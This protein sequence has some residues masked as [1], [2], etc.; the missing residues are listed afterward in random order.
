MRK[1]PLVS[2]IFLLLLAACGDKENPRVA[3][4]SGEI[5]GLGDDTLYVIGMDR[6]FDRVD[7]LVVHEDRFSD[8]I[9][10]DTLVGVSLLFADGTTYPLY[11]DRRE[12]IRIS[13]SADRLQ[14]LQVTGSPLN[15][16][17]TAFSQSLA[18]LSAPTD[19]AVQRRA[20]DFIRQ[21]PASLVSLWLLEKYF[22]QVPEPDLDR[23]ES[24][25][26]PLVGEIKDRPLASE[27]M[28][29]LEDHKKLSVGRSL[30]FIQTTD[31]DGERVV[32]TQ[33]NDQYLLVHVWA[34]WD[35]ASRAANDS[36]R[37]LHRRQKRNKDFAMLGIS[38][39][40]DRTMW[41]DAISRDTLDWTQ[42]CDL[43]GW[44]SDVVKKCYVYT[45]PFNVLVN[46]KGRIMGINLTPAQVEEKIKKK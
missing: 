33:F 11:L 37:A 46:P 32:R 26:E 2:F 16:E 18:E 45:L 43:H 8:T 7:T 35:A 5:K 38:L 20:A 23:I 44:E 36:L 39:D 42:G 9:P 10:V 41:L 15:E 31:A 19:T 3:H 4:V 22:V 14:A 6:L 12:R 28:E 34:S 30:P 17:Q 40:T 25:I 1:L 24:L 21:H 27:L 29:L 13:G